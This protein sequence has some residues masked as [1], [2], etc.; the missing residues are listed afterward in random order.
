MENKTVDGN[1][2]TVVWHVEDLNIS[3]KNEDTVD[4]LINKL[5]EQYRKEVDL[6]IHRGKVHEYLGMKLDYREEGK[7]KIDMTDDLKKILDDLPSKYQG[8]A[9]APAEKHLF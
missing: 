4:A 8:R 9:I 1:Q 3:H 6:A 2:V 7:V 5:R